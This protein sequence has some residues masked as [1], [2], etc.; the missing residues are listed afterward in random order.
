MQLRTLLDTW[1]HACAE[2]L[3]TCLYGPFDVVSSWLV[4]LAP[5]VL[6]LLY[7]F[8]KW[9]LGRFQTLGAVLLINSLTLILI[10]ATVVAVISGLLADRCHDYC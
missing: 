3:S 8:R 9:A 7:F 1:T 2:A 5:I 6:A 4:F 10:S